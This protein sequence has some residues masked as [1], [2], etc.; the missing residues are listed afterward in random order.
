MP[1]QT[2]ETRLSVREPWPLFFP[3]SASA[4]AACSASMSASWSASFVR[5]PGA[6]EAGRVFHQ[7][8]LTDEEEESSDED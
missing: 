2:I 6:P 4:L 3:L 8:R 7:E 5:E 1:K